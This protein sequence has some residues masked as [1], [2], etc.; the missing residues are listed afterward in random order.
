M[1]QP[2]FLQHRE[3][4]Q[5]LRRKDLYELRAEA[6][7]LVLLDQLVQVGREQLEDEAQMVFVDE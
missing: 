1:N 3:C 6:L 2:G 4:V 7:E 5:E